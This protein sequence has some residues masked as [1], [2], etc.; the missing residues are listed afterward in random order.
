[1]PVIVCILSSLGIENFHPVLLLRFCLKRVKIVCYKYCYAP[2]LWFRL[3]KPPLRAPSASMQ[4]CQRDFQA[5]KASQKPFSG[6]ALRAAARKQKKSGGPHLGCRAA[7]EELGCRPWS[8][9]YSQERQCEPQFL[10][11]SEHFWDHLRTHFAHV[12]M[13]RHNFMNDRFRLS[14]KLCAHESHCRCLSKSKVFQQGLHQR[15]LP[16]P[17]KRPGATETHHFLLK[18]HLDEPIPPGLHVRIN[19]STHKKEVKLL[20]NDE[21]E[22][23]TSVS[24]VE[25]TSTFTDQEGENS[26]LEKRLKNI[27]AED[28]QPTLEFGETMHAVVCRCDEQRGFLWREQVFK[29]TNWESTDTIIDSHKAKHTQQTKMANRRRIAPT[30]SPKQAHLSMSVTAFPGNC[31]ALRQYESSCRMP[32]LLVHRPEIDEVKKKY[33]PYEELKKEFESLKMSV[34]TDLEV[35]DELFASYQK[36]ME[37]RKTHTMEELGN[38]NTLSPLEESHLSILTDLEYM[39]HQVDNAR[40]FVLSGG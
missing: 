4:R 25:K 29:N 15:P 19:L 7:V 27:P 35:M 40:E 18:Q 11:A 13:L 1:M 31:S 28:I 8:G 30:D 9:S 20:D 12:Q 34:K 32:S 24:V 3:L 38:L 39:V 21:T 26:D 37:K 33:Q 2:S 23:P 10:V 22:T 17:P 16:G 5:L 6:I 14:S 36:V